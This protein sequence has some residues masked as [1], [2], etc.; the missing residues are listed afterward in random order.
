MSKLIIIASIFFRS[1]ATLALAVPVPATITVT[2]EVV[3]QG[4][5]IKLVIDSATST[6]GISSIFFDGI[7][8]V[9]FVYQ[10]KITA[11][12]GVDLNRRVGTYD[13]VV[14]FADGSEIKKGIVVNKREKIEAPL[15]IPESLGG[16]TTASASKL[17]SSL[18]T[19]NSR[20]RNIR[21]FPRSLWAS[22]FDYPTENPIITDS[23]G[24]SRQ[25]VGYSIAHKGTDFRAGIGTKVYAMNRGI[26]RIARFGRAY[27]NTI[28]I[29]HGLGLS[30][31]YLHLSKLL[32]NEG[33]LVQK[34]QLIG[35]SGD[36]GYAE[37]PHLHTSVWIN[38]VS[39]DPIKF[40][41]LF[42]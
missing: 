22:S 11:L 31:I 42:R 40:M 17:V 3:L 36:T 34:G 2:P 30:T 26:V 25:T 6:A 8:I 7:N 13:V 35:L 38:N 21:T 27:G 4:E 39:V 15:G 5:P 16:N 10:G 23:Y 33:E 18:T 19:E 29:D 12:I 20:L 41:S 37:A 9:P 1:I 32:V 14:K 24:Y 28:E